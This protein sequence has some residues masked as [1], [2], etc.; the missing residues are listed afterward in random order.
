MYFTTQISKVRVDLET[1]QIELNERLLSKLNKTIEL[2]SYIRM[3]KMSLIKSVGYVDRVSFDF[4]GGRYSI[5]CVHESRTRI[6]ILN[7]L[8]R[9]RRRRIS[10]VFDISDILEYLKCSDEERSVKVGEYEKRG[11]KHRLHKICSGE[12][13]LYNDIDFFCF[14]DHMMVKYIRYGFLVN[15]DCEILM[16]VYRRGSCVY[17]GDIGMNRIVEIKKK[18][19]EMLDKIWMKADI[20]I[21]NREIKLIKRLKGVNISGSSIEEEENKIREIVYRASKMV[22]RA[23]IDKI[24]N[25]NGSTINPIDDNTV[26]KLISR[27]P[28]KKRI[29]NLK[30][31]SRYFN[32]NEYVLDRKN[33]TI[34]ILSLISEILFENGVNIIKYTVLADKKIMVRDR[35]LKINGRKVGQFKKYKLKDVKTLEYLE[36]TLNPR[37]KNDIHEYNIGNLDKYLKPDSYNTTKE[38]DIYILEITQLALK[39]RRRAEEVTIQDLVCEKYVEWNPVKEVMTD[40]GR[41]DILTDKHLIETKF[42]TGYKEALGQVLSY[43][44]DYPEHEKII[45]LFGRQTCPI[46]EIRRLC[47]KY[48]VK[49]IVHEEE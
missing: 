14:M 39:R 31:I 18:R 17:D 46:V 28:C 15:S 10:Q 8:R 13:V 27:M 30:N 34:K 48:D 49:V 22:K 38:G 19:N 23:K 2:D 3:S 45:Y 37:Y 6:K 47:E 26:D 43:S 32:K 24:V 12:R 21:A 40:F 16:D 42:Y 7:R 20:E 25:R 36:T 5:E 41:I 4:N 44:D 1:S 33:K 9:P 29:C 35:P 11:N